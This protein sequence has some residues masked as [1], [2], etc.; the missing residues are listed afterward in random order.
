M[1][2]VYA[3][4]IVKGLKDYAD[5]PDRIKEQVKAVLIAANH[6]DLAA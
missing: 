5:V 4:L 2:K 3:D 1:A 6:G